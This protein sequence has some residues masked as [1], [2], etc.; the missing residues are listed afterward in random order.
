MLPHGALA[1]PYK[2]SV[3]TVR[4]FNRQL[5]DWTHA[6]HEVAQ[7]PQPTAR[8]SGPLYHYSQSNLSL[9]F[10]PLAYTYVE[11]AQLAKTHGGRHVSIA[12]AILRALR[13]GIYVFFRFRWWQLGEHGIVLAII[14]AYGK[15]MN[16]AVL[17]ERQRLQNNEGV[18][19]ERDIADC[20][21]P[22]PLNPNV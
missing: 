15:F 17:W 11:A 16:Y 3:G 5:G 7:I 1:I 9:T 10:A 20:W 13:H 4:L 18:W 8:V 12:E 2:S 19:L 22:H 6:L 21:K 14:S